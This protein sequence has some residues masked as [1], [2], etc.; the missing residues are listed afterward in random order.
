[1]EYEIQ[2]PKPC[3]EDW[4]KM[5]ASERGRFCGSCKKEVI[6]FTRYSKEELANRI[7]TG[8]NI[9][10]R[11]LAH[12][13][14]TNITS[15]QQNKNT[16]ARLL[17]GISSLLSFGT[18]SLEAKTNLKPLLN[19][20]DKT[21]IWHTNTT[22]ASAYTTI[23]GKVFNEDTEEEL[24]FVSVHIKHTDILAETN[25]N[26]NYEIKIPREY[27]TDRTVVMEL[28]YI[29]YENKSIVINRNS[30]VINIPL[31]GDNTLYGKHKRERLTVVLGMPNF[32]PKARKE[33]I[34]TLANVTE[35]STSDKVTSTAGEKTEK[36]MPL[37]PQEDYM[38]IRGK[39]T[40]EETGEELI[41]TAIYIEG[42]KTGTIS[43]INGFYELNIPLTY[44]KDGKI[45]LKASYI[46]FMDYHIKIDKNTKEQNVSLEIGSS[47][48]G[49]I[50]IV[51][52]NTWQKVKNIFRKR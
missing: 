31:K 51:K 3:H 26:G 52:P 35:C 13:L 5:S 40:T 47:I 9:C 48:M 25:P 28:N 39:V 37:K 8:A 45:T 14:N 34:R 38:T 19:H 49:D 29:G 20:Q 42:T 12:Q 7:D 23:K 32:T 46:G 10:G 24:A 15:K 41:G 21:E 17:I 43:D 44:F 50:I 18:F 30:K 36:K 4:A 11:F 6:D 27:F 33:P 22:E 1:M 16:N 2:I